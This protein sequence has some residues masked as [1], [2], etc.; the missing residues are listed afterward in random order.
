V[1][2]PG[3]SATITPR[4]SSS[5]ILVTVTL[6]GG[7]NSN[8]YGQ[9]RIVRDSTPIAIGDSD[10]GN[11]T[12]ATFMLGTEN[13]ASGSAKLMCFGMT[14]LDSPATS[15]AVTYKVQARMDNVSGALLTINTPGDT[16]NNLS[17][18]TRGVSSITLM[19]IAE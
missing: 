12:E 16:S 13:T 17:Y 3:I 10:G 18:I 6:T 14:T 7:G 15:S 5:R 9:G 8:Q 19:E 4:S 1:D 2:I 11:R